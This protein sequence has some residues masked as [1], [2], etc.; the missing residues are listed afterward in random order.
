MQAF[1]RSW[2]TDLVPCLDKRL[3]RGMR[4]FGGLDLSCALTSLLFHDWSAPLDSLS[5]HAAVVGAFR[6]IAVEI[7]HWVSA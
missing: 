7:M 6:V 3:L 5:W 4:P 2:P 1:C